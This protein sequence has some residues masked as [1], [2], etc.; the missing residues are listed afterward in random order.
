M[1]FTIDFIENYINFHQN[2]WLEKHIQK[3]IQNLDFWTLWASQNPSKTPPKS[4]KNR[5][6]IQSAFQVE[7]K[8]VFCEK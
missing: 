7:K 3:T 4:K 6:K 2:D 1:F 8:W 5:T